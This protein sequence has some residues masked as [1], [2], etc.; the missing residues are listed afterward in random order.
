MKSYFSALKMQANDRAK[1]STLSILGISNPS[2]RDHLS[3]LLEREEPFVNGPVFEQMFGW[4]KSDLTMLDLI[5]KG[6]LTEELVT[7]LDSKDNGRYAFKSHWKPF[8]HQLKA[9]EDLLAESPQSRVITSGTGSG[10]TECFIVPVL[11][12][13]LRLKAQN[14]NSDVG[15]HALFL[16]PLNALI[17]SQKERLNAWTKHFKGDIRFCL[18]NGNTPNEASGRIKQIQQNNPHE[19]LSRRSMRDKPAQ[20]LV[21]NGTMLEYMLV[22]Q[23]DAPIIEKSKRKLRWIVLDEAH[24]YVGSQAAELALQLRRVLQAFEVEAKDVR[25]VATSATIAGDDAENQLA[26]YL[27]NLAGID[28]S[29]IKVI[30]G[31]RDVPKITHLNGPNL[32]LKDL[33]SI[34]QGQEV[35]SKRFSALS[36]SSLAIAI[37]DSLTKNAAPSTATKLLK[38]LSEYKL[39]EPTLYRWLDLCTFTKCEAGSES[40]LKLRAHYFQRML[41]GLW[42][43]IDT[44]CPAKEGTSLSEGWPFGYVSTVHR[45]TCDCGAPVL[46]LA[47]CQECPEPHLLG[48]AINNGKTLAQWTNKVSDEFSLLDESE[49]DPEKERE[50]IPSP[51]SNTP[52]V[53]SRAA[54][55]EYQ[56][57]DIRVSKSGELASFDDDAINIAQFNG[58]SSCCSACGSSGSRLSASPFRRALLGA[59]FYSSNAVPTLLEYCPDIEPYIEEGKATKIGPSDLPGR[60]RRLITFTDSRQGTARM[61]IRMQQEAERCRLR[62]LVVKNLKKAI[63]YKTV[64]DKETES[65][66]KDYMSVPDDALKNIIIGLKAIEPET[67]KALQVYLDQKSTGDKQAIPISISWNELAGKISGDKDVQNSMLTENKRLSPEIFDK[68]DGPLKLANMLLTREFA[69]RP[70]RQNNLETQGLVRIVYP[71][72]NVIEKPPEKW[73]FSMQDW[74]DFLK[75][76]IDFYVR[77]NSFTNIKG[78]WSKWIGMHFYPKT[79][80]SPESKEEETTRTKKWPQVRE[81]RSIQQKII[82]ILSVI[83]EVDLSTSYGV[84]LVNDWLKS[85]WNDLRRCSILSADAGDNIYSL[86]IDAM[87]FSLMDEAFVCPVTN[88]LLDVTLRGIT[89]YIP[90]GAAAN[91]YRCEKIKLPPVW[92]YEGDEADYADNVESIRNRINS[93][94]SVDYLRNR[95]LWTDINDRAVEG[96]F[97]YATAEHSA[98]QSPDRLQTYEDLFKRGR[99]NVLNCSTT[100]EMGV[101]IGGIAAVVMNNVPPHPANYLQRAGRA[102]RS[103]ESRALGFTL[104][105]GNPH[106]MQVFDDPEWAFKTKIPAPNVEFSSEKLVQRHVNSLLLA[107]FLNDVIGHTEKEKINLSL[108]W[109]YF[110]LDGSI[111]NRFVA[112]LDELPNIYHMFVRKLIRGTELE[113]Y[114]VQG[115]SQIAANKISD[116]TKE[117]YGEYN[118]IEDE[119]STLEEESAYKHKLQM[120]RS[121]LCREYLLRS[122]ATKGF[123]PGYGFPTDVVS[124][125]TYNAAD[126]RNR[127][128]LKKDNNDDREDNSAFIG[129]KPSRNLAVAIREYAPGTDIAIDGRVFRSAGIA[130]NWQKVHQPDAIEEQKFDLA[131]RCEKCGQTGYEEN[132]QS[133]QNENLLCTNPSCASSIPDNDDC[134]R[135]VIRPT[136]FTV[137]F[138]GEVSNNIV[139]Q[140]YVPVQPAWVSAKGESRPLPVSALGYFIADRNGTVFQHSSGL[141]GM[142]YAMCLSCGRA[143]SMTANGFPRLLNPENTHKAPR[144][145][146]FDRGDGGVPEDCQGGSKLLNN[147]HIGGHIHTDVFELAL[148]NPSSGEYLTP[149][150]DGKGRIIATTLAVALRAALTRVLGIANNEVE[151]CVRQALVNNSQQAYMLQLFDAISGGAGFATSA[152]VHILSILSGMVDILRCDCEAYCPKCLLETDTRHDAD[153]LNRKFALEWLGEEFKSTLDAPK[154]WSDWIKDAEYNPLTIKQV[155]TEACGRTPFPKEVIFVLS[156]DFKSWDSSFAPLQHRIHN[157]LSNGIKVS[158][159]LTSKDNIRE[160]LKVL[161]SKLEAIGVTIGFSAISKPIVAQVINS[162]SCLTIVSKD[163]FCRVLGEQWLDSRDVTVTTKSENEIQYEKLSFS[164]EKAND[165]NTFLLEIHEEFNGKIAQFGLSF[166][167]KVFSISSEVAEIITHQKLKSIIYSDRYLQSPEPVLLLTEVLSVLG[168]RKPDQITIETFFR[169][170]ER[171]SST[172]SHNWSSSLD[173]DNI[174]STWIEYR[175]QIQPSI[176]VEYE[177]R[178]TPHRRRMS[179]SFESGRCVN[180]YLD[181]GFGYW[182]LNCSKGAHRF[183]FHSDLKTQISDMQRAFQNSEVK[184]GGDWKTPITIKL[185]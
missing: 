114:P 145:S 17:N 89:P 146:K 9:W 58:D 115:L 98:Q 144:P 77:E 37:R 59:P 151:F 70:R 156:S 119:L 173:F 5:S 19:V 75:V 80:L 104:C 170:N 154:V 126:Y 86:N 41:Q 150:L 124:I 132:L 1:E 95:N 18:F 142:G 87:G 90:K 120:E 32:S 129:G 76:T 12:D 50:D 100:M 57:V 103:Q 23:A 102:G 108:E 38:R 29:Q 60:G 25:F 11:Q 185:D 127:R 52:I 72:L 147:I 174:L 74:R 62:G 49:R 165:K 63:E 182:R 71:A 157:L 40:F 183:S 20:I 117:W 53:F 134:R 47:F 116:L 15:V 61:S 181:Q 43:C 7:A 97:Y 85:A 158:M 34:D 35:S 106:D 169:D 162:N 26:Q 177:L 184:N 21:T 48:A 107:R 68:S 33:E 163:D 112:W 16:Y 138:Y 31:K 155:L 44:N 8:K 109:F 39:D 176:S 113:K 167:K 13:L 161:L 131:W 179:L 166:W 93:S 137:D 153:L 141:Y 78:D 94:E 3:K 28:V 24:T 96:G 143:E 66:I 42:S 46:E 122:L 159:T 172:I 36:S 14:N 84:D 133:K 171:S 22:R 10:K 160:E 82:R 148:R 83:S 51:T 121:R 118:Y 136:G 92:E 55:A 65:L 128:N 64:I 99:K 69:R 88:K 139:H 30:G 4:E 79:L 180:I 175:T 123:L 111:A 105:K 73:P 152:P 164:A 140:S 67:A 149:T 110:P 125:D 168:K 2:L 130:L 178:D 81:N 27:S 6:I 91:D 135:K 56:Y 101:D 45:Q 54:S